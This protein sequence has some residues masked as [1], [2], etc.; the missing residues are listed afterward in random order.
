MPVTIFVKPTAGDIAVE[1]SCE[2]AALIARL[3]QLMQDGW[4]FFPAEQIGQLAGEV[5]QEGV[6]VKDRDI[7]DLIQAGLV[8]V[9]DVQGGWEARTA[10]AMSAEE[11]AAADTIAIRGPAARSTRRGG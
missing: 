11:A 8:R 7:S 6:R 4:R 10:D 3:K 1:W 2:P 9:V 5:A